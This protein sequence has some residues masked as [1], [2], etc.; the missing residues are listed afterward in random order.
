MVIYIIYKDLYIVNVFHMYVY[1]INTNY[2]AI[3]LILF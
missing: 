1:N 3:K 2:N